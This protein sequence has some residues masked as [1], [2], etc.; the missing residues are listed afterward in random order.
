MRIKQDQWNRNL[1]FNDNFWSW[2]MV[3]HGWRME[4][5]ARYRGNESGNEHGDKI[6]GPWIHSKAE[7]PWIV[8]GLVQAS[9]PKRMLIKR[10]HSWCLLQNYHLRISGREPGNMDLKPVSLVILLNIN[11]ESWQQRVRIWSR[12]AAYYAL[13]YGMMVLS[14]A[15]KVG[16][17]NN[18]DQAG[19]FGPGPHESWWGLKGL[20]GRSYHLIGHEM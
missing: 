14:E 18:G 7:L 9:E 11:V 19:G 6:E 3:Q 16:E 12:R 5:I 20:R 15:W 13:V 10:A 2:Q 1:R 4:S 8:Q 17:S